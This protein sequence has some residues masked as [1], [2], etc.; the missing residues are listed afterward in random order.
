MVEQYLSFDDNLESVEI[1]GEKV[2]VN[3]LNMTEITSAQVSKLVRFISKVGMAGADITVSG[4]T[5]NVDEVLTICG[6]ASR[7]NIAPDTSDVAITSKPNMFKT[8]RE[9]AATLL[10]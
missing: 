5:K 1:Y 6:L 10:Q 9:L 2:D 4:N 7:L 3:L 8:L